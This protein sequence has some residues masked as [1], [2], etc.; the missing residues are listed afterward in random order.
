MQTLLNIINKVSKKRYTGA[1]VDYH[2]TDFLHD[3]EAA[4]QLV[5]KAIQLIQN[6]TTNITDN[7][8]S[9]R[10]KWMEVDS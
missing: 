2:H 8:T 6:K 7:F 1:A 10:S 9:I 5:A 3:I 4:D